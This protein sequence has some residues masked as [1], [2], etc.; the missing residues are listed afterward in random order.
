MGCVVMDI[1]LILLTIAGM[2]TLTAALI[3][4]LAA[5][6]GSG[7]WLTIREWWL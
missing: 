7:R 5:C 4:Y 1:L 3:G 6:A 2:T